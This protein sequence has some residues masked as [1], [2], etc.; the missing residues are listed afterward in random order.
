VQKVGDIVIVGVG[1]PHWVKSLGYTV[2]SAWNIG[3]KTERQF[4]AALE[5]Y[6]MNEIIDFTNLIP[7]YTLAL[8][9]LNHELLIISSELAL[10]LASAIRDRFTREL[11]T[12][13]KTRAKAVLA[14]GGDPSCRC[15]DCHKEL[16]L[17]YAKCRMC[18]IESPRLGQHFR[19]LCLHC[20]R[21]HDCGPLQYVQKYKVKEVKELLKRVSA[22][23]KQQSNG[24][25]REHA[26]QVQT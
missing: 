5:R 20:A 8:D 19:M 1:T 3:G 17:F 26:E 11:D 14:D 10:F 22:V 21:K 15:T 6:M 7:V 23:H 9:L 2:N 13:K 16:F 4:T 18:I 24:M 25:T 12:F